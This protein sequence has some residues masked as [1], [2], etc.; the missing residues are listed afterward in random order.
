M[1]FLVINRMKDMFA[2][3][4]LEQQAQIAE[5]GAA[6]IEKYK[7]AGICKEI[8]DIAS[9]HGGASIWEVDSA[10]KGAALFLE[11]PW[12]PFSDFEM[13]TLSDFDAMMKA[14]KEMYKKLLTKK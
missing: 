1:K 5:A 13:Y 11:N 9:I 2:M 10:E 4:P 8:Y 12:Y 7:K 3:I 6:F 14:Q